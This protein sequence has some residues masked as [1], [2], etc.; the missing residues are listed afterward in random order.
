MPRFAV[1]RCL[2]VLPGL[3]E[4]RLGR[5]LELLSAADVEAKTASLRSQ[6]EGVWLENLV[7][8]LCRL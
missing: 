1:R 2:E 4:G 8:R 7:A 5:Q 3:T 6:E